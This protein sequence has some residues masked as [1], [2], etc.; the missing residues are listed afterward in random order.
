MGQSFEAVVSGVTERGIYAELANTVEGFIDAEKLGF[1]L[2]YD[3]ERFCLYDEN[4][5]Y[6]LGDR[7]TVTVV[8]VNRQACKIDFDLAQNVDNGAKSV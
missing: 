8:S 1:R 6:R 3:P 2:K 5:R 4:V 7:V